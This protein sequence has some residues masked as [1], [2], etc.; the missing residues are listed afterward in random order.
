MSQKTC[1]NTLTKSDD[2][3]GRKGTVGLQRHEEM[4]AARVL[5]GARIGQRATFEHRTVELVREG[6]WR[7]P[8]CHH[9]GVRGHAELDQEAG[10]HAVQQHVGEETFLNQRQ[11]PLNAQRRCRTALI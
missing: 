9:L 11:E 1:R 8:L 10:D 7:V 4:A 6:V 5:P 3:G 2:K